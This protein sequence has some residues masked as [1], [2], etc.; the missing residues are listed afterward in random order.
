MV[1][2]PLAK[3]VGAAIFALLLLGASLCVCVCWGG[4]GKGEYIEEGEEREEG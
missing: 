2:P 4:M 3:D 1:V